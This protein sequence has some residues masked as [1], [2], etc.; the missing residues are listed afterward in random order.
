MLSTKFLTW[1]TA[2]NE[3]LKRLE[4]VGWF[5]MAIHAIV[6]NKTARFLIGFA[7]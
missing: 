5:E 6:E 4:M 2:T 7:I 1:S 3:A